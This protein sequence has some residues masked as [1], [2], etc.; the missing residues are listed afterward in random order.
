M[1]PQTRYARS[2]DVNIAYQ[3]VGEGPRDLVLVP[4]W[5][6][7]IEV[8]WEH[9][10][11]A[12]FLNRLASFC[13]LILFD[14]RGTGLSDR[15]DIPGIETRMDDVRAVMDATKSDRA[16]L[17]GYSEGGPMC[18]VFAATYPARAAGL[19]MHGSYARRVQAPD[20]PLGTPPSEWERFVEVTCRDWGGPVGLEQRAPSMFHD[21]AFREWWAR[22][23]RMS[24][25]PAGN[26]AIL[27]MNAQIDVRHVLPS[28]RVPTLVLHPEGDR[29]VRVELG[30]YLARQIPGSRYV[31]MP[32]IDHVPFG[33]T[34][35][36]TLAEIETFITSLPEEVDADRVLATVMFTDIVSSTERAAELGDRRWRE[37]LQGFHGAV[38][39]QLA[40]FRGREIDTA[41]DGVL[42][43]FDGPARA[44]RCAHAVGDVVK[45]L[46]LRVRTGVHT[47]ECEVMGD[48]LAGIAVHIGARV[49]AAAGE[50]E[51]LV[52]STVRDLVAGSGLRF[53]DRGRQAL[54]GI[55]GEWQLYAVD[56]GGA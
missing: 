30:R 8:F 41:G 56:R 35:D 40:R 13:R 44:V 16:V 39:G 52:S 36:R 50:D 18:A 28:V 11:A 38:R 3:V 27:R 46:G 37:L 48:K 10:A 25:G 12:S 17:F 4:G 31:E 32:G 24:A 19:I 29:T 6:S 43:A 33:D 55:P 26:A 53:S 14:K 42:A 9:P 15:V 23:I 21:E 51:V 2:G 1:P 47:G 34:A 20:Y 45:P 5:L 49:A 7:N 22:F 54:K